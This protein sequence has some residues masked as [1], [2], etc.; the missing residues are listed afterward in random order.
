MAYLVLGREVI[1]YETSKSFFF[2]KEEKV[3]LE[4]KTN[5]KNPPVFLSTAPVPLDVYRVNVAQ[6]L[7][8]SLHVLC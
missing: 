6:Q 5:T 3:N 7:E 1:M 2:F 8:S 4:R